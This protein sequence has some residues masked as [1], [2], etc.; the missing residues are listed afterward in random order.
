M[1]RKGRATYDDI[2]NL[3]D[4][5]VGEIIAGEL[6]VSPRPALPHGLAQAAIA[7]SLFPFNRQPGGPGD[8]GGWWFAVEP[9]LHLHDDIL[10]PDLA[11]WRRER[12]P[13]MPN[14]AAVALAPDWICEILSPRTVRHDRGAKS[15]I[16]ARE[17]VARSWL[18]DPLERTLE[19]RRLTGE[20]WLGVG[21]FEG[22]ATVR[23][24]PFADLAVDLARWWLP[25]EPAP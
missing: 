18:I 15:Q 20:H 4:N 24:E 21:F 5:V 16:Y 8:P 12:M 17:G 7:G 23:A 2:A 13:R 19:I 22:D 1:A 25:E 11:G 6:V 10:V 9:E 14:V 3:P